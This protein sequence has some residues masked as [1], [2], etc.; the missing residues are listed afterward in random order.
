MR[1]THIV[2]FRY[3]EGTTAAQAADVADR[4]RAF[5]WT[6]R[7]GA[8]YIRSVTGGTQASPERAGHGFEH[9]FVVEFASAADRDYYLGRPFLAEEAPYDREHDA[10][11]EFVRPFLADVLVFDFEH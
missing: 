4:F 2:L 3:L 11:K 8:P 1:V 7:D 6:A 10:F 5:A 9:G